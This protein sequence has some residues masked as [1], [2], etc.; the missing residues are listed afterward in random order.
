MKNIKRFSDFL[1]E[2]TGRFGQASSA[3]SS[4]QKSSTVASK[5]A[6]P[7]NNTPAGPTAEAI[8]K[9]KEALTA[10]LDAGFKKLQ[11]WLIDMFVE[12]NPFWNK[13]KSTWNDNEKTAWAALEQQWELDCKPT[14]DDLTTTLAQLTKDVAANGKY[15]SDATMVSL[16]KKMNLNLTEVSGWMTG[17]ADDSLFDTFEGAN[18][19]DTFSWTLN[20]STGPVSKSIDTDF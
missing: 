1:V 3:S 16:S 12:A 13:F 4:G 8:A 6:E 17:R 5:K 7:A 10:K 2:Q 14:L 18:D 19:S 11:D 20:F 15:A 9:E